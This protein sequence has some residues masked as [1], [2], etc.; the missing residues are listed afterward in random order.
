MRSTSGIGIIALAM[1]LINSSCG[2]KQNNEQDLERLRAA[3]EEFREAINTGNGEKVAQMWTNDAIFM[4][5]GSETI[6]GKE[7]VAAIWKR[8]VESGFRTKNQQTIDLAVSGDIGYEVVTQLWTVHQEGKED[9]WASSKFVHIWKKQ[10]DGSWKLHLDI[11]NT[12][13]EL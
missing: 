4:S 5:N 8:N 12:N 6:T 9:E 11:W 10:E 13:P 1:L 3:I 7:Q 2:Q